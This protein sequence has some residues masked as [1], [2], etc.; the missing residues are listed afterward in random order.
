[1][2]LLKLRLA[3]IIIGFG[4]L[5]DRDDRMAKARSQTLL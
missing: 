2:K 1:M 4:L 5:P 3:A